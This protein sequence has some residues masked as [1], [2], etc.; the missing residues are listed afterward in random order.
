M[1]ENDIDLYMQVFAADLFATKFKDDLLNQHA[2]LRFRNQVANNAL[3]GLLFD[4]IFM[5]DLNECFC[6]IPGIGSRR[7]KRSS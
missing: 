2:G 3:L 7:L 6:T 1:I 5:T 4:H